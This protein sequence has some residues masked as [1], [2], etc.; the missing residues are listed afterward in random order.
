MWICTTIGF[1]SVCQKPSDTDLT[2]RTRVKADLDELRKQYLPTL[3]P[4]I[5]GAGTDYPYRAKVSH[6]DLA[7]AMTK[8]VKDIDYGNFKQ[9]VEN[10]QGL[11]R[12]RIYS[13]VWGALHKMESLE[14]EQ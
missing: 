6:G 14:S 7:E 3:G 11:E 13:K 1:F 5:E 2:V 8:L 10:R 12:E 4:T 9:A